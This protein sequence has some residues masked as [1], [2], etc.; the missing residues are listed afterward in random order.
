MQKPAVLLLLLLTAAVWADI[1]L[2]KGPSG[3]YTAVV[4][5]STLAIDG[6]KHAIPQKL[7]WYFNGSYTAYG[8]YYGN[9][10]CVL[11]IWPDR[12]EFYI[13]CTVGTDMTVV[14]L[15]DPKAKI[16]CRDKN[17]V[18]APAVST[19]HLEIYNA[20]GLYLECKSGFSATVS[21]PNLLLALLAGA[22]AAS[23]TLLI[24][25]GVLLL[26]RAFK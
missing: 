17:N 3:N 5:G 6:Q 1:V 11:S 20:K 13:T 16:T 15:K 2:V 24:A 25:L 4:N 22:S 7:S 23:A 19:Q 14:A 8:I 12:P 9:P 21:T 18:L 26:R 10:Q